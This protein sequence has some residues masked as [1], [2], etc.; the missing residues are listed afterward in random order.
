[1]SVLWTSTEAQAATRGRAIGVWSVTGISIDT[2]TLQEGDLFVP[3]KDI[4]DGHDF[5]PKAYECGAGAVISERPMNDAPSLI[6]KD[7]LLALQDL[8]RAAVL[9]STATRIAVTGSVGKTSVKE[10][11]AQVFTAYGQT[12][13]SMKSFNNHWGVPL[14]LASMP[15]ATDFGIFELGMN[16]KGELLDLSGLVKPQTAI[17]TK[18]APAHLEFFKSVTDIAKA[19]AEI[20]AGMAQGG[21][22]ILPADSP[23]FPILKDAASHLRVLSFGRNDQATARIYDDFICPEYSTC[24]V[25]ISGKSYRIKI[26][27]SGTHHLENAAVVLLTVYAQNLPL[28]ICLNILKKINKI[29]GRGMK[30]TLDIDGKKITLIDESYNANPESMAAALRT[31]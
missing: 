24:K 15:R 23:H 19:K 11:L 26:P 6:V 31:L 20:F 28:E 4:R 5:I 8:A 22:A 17:V 7:S 2:R 3:L 18:I 30:Y 10:A 1:M 25:E 29:A 14:S 21:T 13:R 12:H 16:H 9:R 27:L